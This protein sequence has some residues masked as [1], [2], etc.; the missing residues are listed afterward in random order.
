[1][2]PKYQFF[3]KMP[4]SRILLKKYPYELLKITIIQ[5]WND[6]V[7]KGFFIPL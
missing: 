6:N 2:V 3:L 1:M 4:Q 5:N 7:C